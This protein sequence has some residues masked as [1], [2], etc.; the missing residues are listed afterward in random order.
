MAGRRVV[1]LLAR[2]DVIGLLSPRATPSY[3]G[4]CEAGN[5]SMQTRTSYEAARNGR[6]G[7]WS[8]DDCETARLQ[9]YQTARPWGV[10]GPTPEQVW[11][12]REP[13]A[14]ELRQRFQKAVPYFLEDERRTRGYL[15]GIELPRN[16]HASIRRVAIRRA[17]VALRLLEVRKGRITLPFSL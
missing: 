16:V 10:T 8:A 1:R 9:A 5:G 14:V 15:P 6:P 13:I 7:R 2:N 4:S 12:K 11:L 3:N 17:L